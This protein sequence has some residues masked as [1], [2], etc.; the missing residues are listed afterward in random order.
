MV[1][2]VGGSHAVVPLGGHVIEMHG[3]WWPDSVGDKWE[4]ALKHARSLEYAVNACRSKRLAVQAGGNIGIWPRRLARDF[5]RVL[6]F[7]PDATSRECL[8]LNVPQNVQVSAM[9]LGEHVGVCGLARKSLGSH[10]IVD[11]DAVPM[12][13][14]DALR[15][16]T[17]DLLQLDVEGYEWHAL[18][19]ARETIERCHP[20][21]QVELRG[22][23]AKYGQSDATVRH[24]LRELGYAEIS[25]QPGSDVVFRWGHA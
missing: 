14:I 4:H 2:A 8:Q 9:A 21:I 3:L 24:L 7:E 11:G 5:Q 17:L 10:R 25:R 18:T 22:F 13:T 23:T 16:D 19:G 15:L 20:L 12:T 1:R 6:T